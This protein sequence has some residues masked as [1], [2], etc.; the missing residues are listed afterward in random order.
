LASKSKSDH[1][2]E[3]L[4]RHGGLPGPGFT[5]V[6]GREPVRELLDRAAAEVTALYVA[7]GTEHALAREI[8]AAR[9]RGIA[10]RVV[11]REEIGR[12]TEA[13]ANHQGVLAEL[14]APAYADLEKLIEQRPDPLIL[15]D[16]VTD[17][18]NLGAALRSAEAAGARAVVL[19]RDRTA[20]LTA[21][22]VK[23]S[24]GAAFHLEIARCG[25]VARTLER[26]KQAGYWAAALDPAGETS[27][28]ELDTGRRLVLVV[29]AE[30]SGV[31]DIVK[32]A[33]DFRV[34]IPMCGRVGSLNVSVALAV[35]LFEIARGRAA[36]A[37]A[38][39]RRGNA[40]RGATA[41]GS[42]K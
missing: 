36:R 2:G 23:T 25:N 5:R 35:A 1:R 29:G 42:A 27:L 8:A 12:L 32:R 24:A 15:V 34:R 26:L 33:A 20:E 4:R 19:A 6:F 40:A 10:I 39:G 16:G 22:A 37:M 11:G 17:P 31:R 28:Y 38:G 41:G 18:R 30:G 13:G 14:R 9:A 7:A 21:T 3:A